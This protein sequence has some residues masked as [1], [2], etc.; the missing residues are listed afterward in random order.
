MCGIAGYLAPSNFNQSDALGIA[1]KMGARIAHR[2]PDGAGEWYDRSSG[3]FLVHRR[4]AIVELTDAGSQPMFSPSGRFCVVFNGEIYNHL[5]LRVTLNKLYQPITWRG[6][7]D[8]ETLVAA[9]DAWGIEKT[10]KS[11]VGMFAIAVWDQKKKT[12]TLARDRLGEKPLYYGRQG[13]CFIF[14]SELQSIRV[15]PSFNA[16][17]DQES[18]AA[19]FRRGYIPAPQ[20]IWKGIKKLIP[21]TLCTISLKADTWDLTK[22]TRYWDFQQVRSDNTNCF[23]RFDDQ[24]AISEF[25]AMLRQSVVGQMNADVPLGAFLS[26]GLDSSLVVSIMQSI[27]A[28]PINTFT[29]G[30]DQVEYNESDVAAN[31]AKHLGTN[32]T[33][34]VVTSDDALSIIPQLSG[35]YGEPFGDSS[36]I[37]TLLVS[38]LARQSLK[39]V[40]SGDGGDELF[41]GY[42][43]Y[44]NQNF[45]RIRDLKTLLPDAVLRAVLPILSRVHF[46]DID[47]AL[48]KLLRVLRVNHRLSIGS[49]IEMALS[50]LEGKSISDQYLA[51]T[52]QWPVSPLLRRNSTRVPSDTL[53]SYVSPI[54]AMMQMD[55]ISYLPDDILTKVD[56][57]AMAVGLETRVPLLDHRIV[58][59]SQRIPLNMKVRDGVTKWLLRKVVNNYIPSHIIDQPKKGFQLPLA[60][61]LRGPLKDWADDNLSPAAINKFGYLCPKIVQR[62][63]ERHKTGQKDLENSLWTILMFQVWMAEQNAT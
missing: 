34:F 20:T 60:E 16:E 39:V 14:G 21:G 24:T 26:G 6:N 44:F 56:R 25:D 28:Q 49:K 8:T 13:N 1:R 7:S 52:N 40:L 53:E 51:I 22:V 31:V 4:L 17:I 63:W 12:L 19:Y 23:N 57:A 9:F 30:F 58:E 18:L 35:I 5:D 46:S 43:R 38:K 15:H 32:H 55:I 36:A 27:S 11:A 54:D 45:T 48:F 37:P 10:L 50:I 62:Q 33:E 3:V 59:F 61:Y 41:A 2:G 29:I 47:F 42:P